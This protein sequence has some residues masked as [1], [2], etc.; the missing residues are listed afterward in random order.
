MELQP[1]TTQMYIGIFQIEKNWTKECLVNL[2]VYIYDR[3]KHFGVP[4]INSKGELQLLYKKDKEDLDN[5]FL[6]NLFYNY[7]LGKSKY[8]IDDELRKK[9]F[10]KLIKHMIEGKEEKRDDVYII[11]VDIPRSILSES[12][13]KLLQEYCYSF[14]ED[15]IKIPVNRSWFREKI[16]KAIKDLRREPISVKINYVDNKEPN[17]ILPYTFLF[18]EGMYFCLLK[19]YLYQAFTHF[20]SL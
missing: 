3:V 12:Q 7:C 18:P 13:F 9:L 17:V 16:E 15:K 10:S 1:I 19:I 8:F 5:D 2:P 11:F 14:N 4:R 6:L 20:S